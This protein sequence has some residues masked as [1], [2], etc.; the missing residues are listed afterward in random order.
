MKTNFSPRNRLLLK[1]GPAL[2]LSV[3][4]LTLSGCTDDI[5][6]GF[7]NANICTAY[8][9]SFSTTA[10][11]G[12]TTVDPA[13]GLPSFLTFTPATLTF[14]GT[15]TCTDFGTYP[16]TITGTYPSSAWNQPGHWEAAGSL[17]VGAP[18]I[19]YTPGI[20]VIPASTAT[21]S[22]TATLN[23]IP[24]CTC[25]INLAVVSGNVSVSAATVTTNAAGTAT[26]TITS[27]SH[28]TTEREFHIDATI[29][30]N[31]VNE[32]PAKSDITGKVR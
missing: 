30:S 2:L 14:S 1:R 18:T 20:L 3:V 8:T 6:I 22:V 19:G 10:A 11:Y 32:P 13:T 15:P 31:N 17:R 28:S 25:K 27:N 24:A 4:A 7:P 29:T 12:T 26:I 21:F 9:H 23:V 5:A 16:V